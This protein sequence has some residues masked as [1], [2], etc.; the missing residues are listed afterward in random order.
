MPENRSIT[1]ISSC[2]QSGRAQFANAE[3]LTE[4]FDDHGADFGAKTAAAYQ[5]AAG[6]FFKDAIKKGY[7]SRSLGGT[8]QIY[9]PKTNTYF[10]NRTGFLGSGPL[11]AMQ[12]EIKAA[13][14]TEGLEAQTNGRP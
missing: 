11:E 12:N 2:V 9:D 8:V 3:L 6:E 4:H 10:L 5:K 13:A 14:L 7:A 1:V